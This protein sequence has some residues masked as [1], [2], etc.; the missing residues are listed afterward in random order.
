MLSA[1]QLGADKRISMWQ[2][3]S[4]VGMVVLQ[5]PPIP[6]LDHEVPWLEPKHSDEEEVG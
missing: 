5:A 4:Q 6:K 3:D 2:P 1:K